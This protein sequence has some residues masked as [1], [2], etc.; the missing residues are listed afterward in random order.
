MPMSL[1]ALTLT[2]KHGLA[3]RKHKYP[4]LHTIYLVRVK[5]SVIK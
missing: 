2:S 4:L 5:S 1:F 3:L